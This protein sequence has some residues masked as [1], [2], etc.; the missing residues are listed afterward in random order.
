MGGEGPRVRR[1]RGG[2]RVQDCT[3]SSA[4]RVTGGMDSTHLE[5]EEEEEEE[6]EGG[7]NG[8]VVGKGAPPCRV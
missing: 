1:G 3:V 8:G 6:E 7:G 2:G 5:E 4:A